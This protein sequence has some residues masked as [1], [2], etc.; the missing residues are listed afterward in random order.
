[1][2]Q[3]LRST[4]QATKASMGVPGGVI[5]LAIKTI[6]QEAYCGEVEADAKPCRASLDTGS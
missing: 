6:G 4:K 1:M 5:I 3:S 2:L